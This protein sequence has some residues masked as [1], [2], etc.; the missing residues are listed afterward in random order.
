M[1]LL[2][3]PIAITGAGGHLGTWLQRRLVLYANEV[4]PLERGD[5]LRGAFRSAAAV[6]HLAGSLAPEAHET[7]ESANVETARAVA[8]A[9]D[10]SSVRRVVFLSHL[11]ASPLARNDYLRTK[12]QAEEILLA[13]G[14]ETTIFRC[15]YV[16]GPPDDPGPSF[17]PFLAHG[18]KPVSVPGDGTQRIAPVF[19]EDVVSAVLRAAIDLTAPVGTYELTGPDTLTL[20]AFLETLNHGHVHE[21][22]LPSLL[23]RA[24]SHLVRELRPA[25]V[26]V[27]LADSLPTGLPSA[28]AAFRLD[29]HHV[30]DVFGRFGTT[31]AA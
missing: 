23:A 25:L 5:D 20:D 30:D 18:E 12:G 4:R 17:T 3:G 27:L 10:G 7:Y 16:Y 13:A 19:V 24:L 14:R 28:A 9:L 1:T 22:H 29:L 26:E 6:V 8:A 31:V 21:R 15:S 11:G 2:Q